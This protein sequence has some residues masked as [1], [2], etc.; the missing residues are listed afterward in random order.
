MTCTLFM[1]AISAETNIRATNVKRDSRGRNQNR[2][3]AQKALMEYLL[4]GKVK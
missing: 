4:P 2:L 1:Q 3:H